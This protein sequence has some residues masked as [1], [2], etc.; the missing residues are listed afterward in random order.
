MAD[1]SDFANTRRWWPSTLMDEMMPPGRV[2]PQDWLAPGDDG[3]T[4]VRDADHSSHVL[5]RIE[6]GT[7][8]EFVWHEKR[9]GVEIL[10]MP[11]GTWSLKDP[12]DAGTLDLFDGSSAPPPP[13]AYIEAANW[14]AEASDYETMMDS[15]DGFA[16]AYAEMDDI[17]PEGRRIPVVM[18]RWS[19]HIAFRVSA[20]GASL[21]RV[22]G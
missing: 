8:V 16:A 15:M 3:V 9:G 4:L 22:H 21:E 20:D 19:K 11:D 2:Q 6:P 18:G 14:F 17:E 1:L 10:L 7:A 5:A 13:V 12:R